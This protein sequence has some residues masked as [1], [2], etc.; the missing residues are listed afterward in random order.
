MSVVTEHARRRTV[1]WLDPSGSRQAM[2]QLSGAE[3]LRQI[4]AGDLPPPPIARLLGFGV[5]HIEEG[6][7]TFNIEPREDLENLAGMLH[8][9]VAATLL[10]NALAASVHTRIPPGTGFVTLDLKVSFVR[11]LTAASGRLVAEGRV[12]HLGRK[13]ALAE[14]DIRNADGELCAHAVGTFS[15]MP[16][17]A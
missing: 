15:L 8:G 11:A 12:L 13:T 5:D 7:V 6:R 10:D 14:G 17:R 4:K 2:A 1:E 9:G 16:P 3:I